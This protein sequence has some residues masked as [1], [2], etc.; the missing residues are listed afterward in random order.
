MEMT[1]AGLV[2]G[3]VAVLGA[4]LVAVVY[5]WRTVARLRAR[6]DGIPGLRGV[7]VLGWLVGSAPE[8]L[9]NYEKIHDWLHALTVKHGR[10]WL[11]FDPCVFQ[12]SGVIVVADPACIEHILKTKFSQYV[13]GALFQQHFDELLGGGIFAVD[14][15]GN[16][17]D[18]A[19]W[20]MQR[21][22]TSLMFSQRQFRDYMMRGTAYRETRNAYRVPRTA[23]LIPGAPSD[24]C[25]W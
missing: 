16:A 14:H 13:K 12:P 11:L 24:D 2:A 17:D 23:V 19:S 6:Y 3:L 1:K 9:R 5:Q 20:R 18:G 7:G 22:M 8:L 25:W 4:G 10:S 15:A 21:K